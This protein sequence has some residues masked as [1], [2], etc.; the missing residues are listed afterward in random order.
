MSRS[1]GYFGRAGTLSI[2]FLW[3]VGA[4]SIE[5]T[6]TFDNKSGELAQV[7]LV[8]PSRPSTEVPDQQS[9]TVSV[10]P[11]EYFFLV[12]Y[13]TDP[14]KYRYGRGDPFSVKQTDFE[15]DAITV[16]LHGVSD[17]NYRIRDS[18]NNEFEDALAT[19]Q[20]RA[21]NT[22]AA[23]VSENRSGHDGGLEGKFVYVGGLEGRFVWPDNSP[24][25]NCKVKLVNKIEEYEIPAYLGADYKVK[26]WRIAR[27]AVIKDAQVNETGGFAFDGPMPGECFLFFKAQGFSVEGRRWV[28]LEDGWFYEDTTPSV[29]VYIY[30]AK[31]NPP[32]HSIEPGTLTKLA[33]FVLVHS[34]TMEDKPVALAAKAGVFRFAWPGMKAAGSSRITIRHDDY[35]GTL[36]HPEYATHDVDGN[37]YETSAKSPLYPGKHSYRVEVVTP[38]LHVYAESVWTSFVVPGDVFSFSVSTDESDPTGRTLKWEASSAVKAIRVLSEAGTFNQVFNERSVQLPVSDGYRTWLVSPVDAQS[39][40]LIP[41]WTVNFWQPETKV[42]K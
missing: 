17:G 19:A 23:D 24:V 6:I 15:A 11:G 33:D 4:Y 42:E 39:D 14:G 21:E 3:S 35:S 34:L 28:E 25:E 36:D 18:S 13:G 40:D 8:G 22:G 41:G 29:I 38:A 7:V 27:D 12:R 32:A 1:C 2:L 37:T 16:T 26:R 30:G 9:A 10:G 31:P 20:Q 5:S